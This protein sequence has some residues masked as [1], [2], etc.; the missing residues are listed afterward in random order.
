MLGTLRAVAFE[1]PPLLQISQTH[2][3]SIIGTA[4]VLWQDRRIVFHN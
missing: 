4:F 3:G 2:A 1:V